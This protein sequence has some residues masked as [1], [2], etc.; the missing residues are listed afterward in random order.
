[1]PTVLGKKTCPA[2]SHPNAELRESKAG[3]TTIYCPECKFQGFAR[4]PK[5]SS[6]LRGQ[7]GAAGSSTAAG[8]TSSAAERSDGEKM[9]RFLRGE[10]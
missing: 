4:S 5:A 9:D 8:D 2:C 3:G 10:K 7:G 6:A 1:M